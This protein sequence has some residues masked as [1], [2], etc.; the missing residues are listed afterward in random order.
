VRH[1]YIKSS[2]GTESAHSESAGELELPSEALRA[3][4]PE[5]SHV[6]YLI[7]QGHGG[8]Q[9]VSLQMLTHESKENKYP[10]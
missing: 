1:T 3:A 8:K 7:V 5:E 9:K 2:T 10:L 4:R 6:V